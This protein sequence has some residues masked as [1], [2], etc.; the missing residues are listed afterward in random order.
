MKSQSRVATRK[1]HDVIIGGGSAGYAAARTACELGS[2]WRLWIRAPQGALYS[3]WLH[4]D[5]GH[6]AFC[7]S[8]GPSQLR[9]RGTDFSRVAVSLSQL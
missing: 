7:R 6:S 9:R 4:A 1:T 3:A 5:K 2:T 8:R